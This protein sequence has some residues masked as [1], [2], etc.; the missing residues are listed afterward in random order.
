MKVKILFF[1]LLFA[2][3]LF[4]QSTFAVSDEKRTIGDLNAQI[5]I[6]MP[7]HF[8]DGGTWYF[9]DYKK[10]KEN[11]ITSGIAKLVVHYSFSTYYDEQGRIEEN[12]RAISEKYAVAVDFSDILMLFILTPALWALEVLTKARLLAAERL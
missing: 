4:A 11:Y 5:R 8:R 7:V 10:L 6:D 2:S 3:I 9:R 12:Q 1:I